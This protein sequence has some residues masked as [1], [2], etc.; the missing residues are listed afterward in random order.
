MIHL[1]VAFSPPIQQLSIDLILLGDQLSGG[2]PEIQTRQISVM[3][4]TSIF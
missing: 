2:K 1:T 4:H 3:I